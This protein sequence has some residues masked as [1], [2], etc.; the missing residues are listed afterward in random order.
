[1]IKKS[2]KE[3]KT[4]TLQDAWNNDDKELFLSMI[5]WLETNRKITSKEAKDLEE[6]YDN[7]EEYKDE[8]PNAKIKFGNLV[9]KVTEPL[10]EFFNY[11]TVKEILKKYYTKDVVD[12]EVYVDKFKPKL[13]FHTDFIQSVE[14]YS[15]DDKVIDFEVMD[16]DDYSN[17]ILAGSN[18]SWEDYGYDDENKILVIKIKQEIEENKS[19][20]VTESI[21][22][23]FE[24]DGA[25]PLVELMEILDDE[26]K[27]SRGGLFGESS[28]WE[29]ESRDED[30]YIEISAIIGFTTP[31]DTGY[32]FANKK[33][34]NQY[35]KEV[36]KVYDDVDRD[37][38]K[39]FEVLNEY[40]PIL[41]ALTIDL[42]ELLIYADVDLGN[43]LGSTEVARERLADNEKDFRKQIQRMI[44]AF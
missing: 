11:G 42:K 32:S 1:M 37:D 24:Y 18:I 15:D 43:G 38:K 35:Y 4:M 7:W 6:I 14:D 16:K 22:E 8:N 17:S 3:G 29:D 20:K 5:D 10:K 31:I 30:R 44:D 27:Y 25:I 34:D 41:F 13:G 9:V 19:L 26:W 36:N 12:F 28:H 39:Y 21:K 40:E 33:V 23:S 2:L